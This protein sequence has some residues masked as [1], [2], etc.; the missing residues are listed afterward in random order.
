MLVDVST[1]DRAFP[2]NPRVPLGMVLILN[3]QIAVILQSIPPLYQKKE[4]LVTIIYCTQRLKDKHASHAWK[5]LYE[6][7][8]LDSIDFIPVLSGRIFN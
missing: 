8:V 3:V 2:T 5:L 6:D 7:L 1:H 4:E